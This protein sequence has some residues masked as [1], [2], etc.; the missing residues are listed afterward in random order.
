V[1]PRLSESNPEDHRHDP[2]IPRRGSGIA[3]I[4]GRALWRD[5]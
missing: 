1:P 2:D 5:D 4:A 3:L